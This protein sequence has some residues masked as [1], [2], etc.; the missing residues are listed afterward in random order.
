MTASPAQPTTAPPP[1]APSLARIPSLDGLRA[2]SIL[3]VVFCHVAAT[4]NSPV[5][6]AA[7]WYARQAAVGV[8]IFFA[9][10]GFLITTLLL[11]ERDATGTVSLRGFYAR[12]ALRIL[13]AFIAYLGFVAVLDHLGWVHIATRDWIAAATYTVNFTPGV[14]P[15]LWHIWSLSVEEHFY[16]LWPPALLLLGLGRA[17]RLALVILLLGPVLRWLTYTYARGTIDIDFATFTRLDAIAVGCLLAMAARIPAARSPLRAL[18]ARPMAWFCVGVGVLVLSVFALGHSGKYTIVAKGLVN[19]LAIGVILWT[20]TRSPATSFGHVLNWAP[21][22]WLGRLSYS[23]YL[24]QQVFLDHT[25]GERW[26]CQ[27]PQNLGL[28]LLAAVL[29]YS[30]IELPVLRLRSRWKQRPR[31]APTPCLNSAFP[32]AAAAHPA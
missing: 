2:V 18:D 32:A 23:L 15:Q 10:S 17:G 1:H 3:L 20:A 25:N 31:P 4:A 11:R 26:I 7:H 19:A 21:L 5:P 28:A 16:V 13:P 29:S 22:A 27:F 8:D 30:L 12:R 14:P 6:A 24:W 9:I